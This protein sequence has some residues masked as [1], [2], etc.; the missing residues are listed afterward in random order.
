MII[1]SGRGVTAARPHTKIWCGGTSL[2]LS[3]TGT[4]LTVRRLVWDQKIGGSNPPSPTERARFSP[5]S[6]PGGP[7]EWN[8]SETKE[9]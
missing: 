9:G 1:K 4:G 6:N 5:G 8:A 3:Y 7:T 2:A